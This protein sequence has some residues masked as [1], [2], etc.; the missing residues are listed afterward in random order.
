MLLGA[1]RR[2]NI[3]ITNAADMTLMKT[4]LFDENEFSAYLS[5]IGPIPQRKPVNIIKKAISMYL[6][7]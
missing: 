1:D 2:N 5:N 6:P 7:F 3:E 4:A